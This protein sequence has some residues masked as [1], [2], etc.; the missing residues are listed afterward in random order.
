M[1]S[2]DDIRHLEVYDGARPAMSRPHEETFIAP[3]GTYFPRDGDTIHIN[4][5]SPVT[6]KRDLAYGVRLASV[7]APEKPRLGITDQ[8]LMRAG[9]PVRPGDPGIAA[10]NG[11]QALCKDRALM[12]VPLGVDKFKR[13]LANVYVSGKPGASFEPEGAVSLEHALAARNLVGWSPENRMPSRII[14]ANEI[15]ARLGRDSF[16]LG[17]GRGGSSPDP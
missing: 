4:G 8:V 16:G 6:G 7:M 1:I 2:R 17:L 9:R 12:I 15:G 3:P 11:I 14:T 5:K 13:L 10:T